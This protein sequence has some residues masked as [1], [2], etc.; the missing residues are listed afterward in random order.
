MSS[1]K[2]RQICLG[3]NVLISHLFSVFS[4]AWLARYGAHRVVQY[5]S[6]DVDI[7]GDNI[8]SSGQICVILY[9]AA[10]IFSQRK[11]SYGR[12]RSTLSISILLLLLFVLCIGHFVEVS[13]DI[14]S[15][16]FI[17]YI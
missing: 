15:L 2:W 1:A 17:I 12:T 3:L 11:S 13:F 16:Y 10:A 7:P 8:Y 14:S 9:V 4:P 6:P 5:H